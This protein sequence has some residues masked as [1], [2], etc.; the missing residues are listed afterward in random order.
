MASPNTLRLAAAH[1]PWQVDLAPAWGGAWLSLRHQNRGGWRDVGRPTDIDAMRSFD[2]LR[3]TAWSLLPYSNRIPAG[4]V[5]ALCQGAPAAV[6]LKPT[7]PRFSMPIHGVGWQRA[8]QVLDVGTAHCLLG[9]SAPASDWPW[10]FSATQRIDL[11]DDQLRVRLLLKN[12]STLDMPSGLGWHPYFTRTARA[13]LRMRLAWRDE[14]DPN[15]P[16]GPLHRRTLDQ[17]WKDGSPVQLGALAPVDN[18]YGGWD[19]RASLHWPEWGLTLDLD[20]G[21][22]LGGHCVLFAPDAASF[23]C[24]EPVSH[25]NHALSMPLDAATANGIVLLKP[26][27]SL[28]GEVAL[29]MR[30][31]ADMTG[32]PEST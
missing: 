14:Y 29:R 31:E 3:L 26:G 1:T 23:I 27:E 11:E 19:G 7:D 6:T 4:Q 9:L 22:A 24:I 32:E 8:W 18:G 15:D 5:R 17:R 21:G 2:P 30:T 16:A 13:S 12:E 20:A 25:A 10:A 28:Q